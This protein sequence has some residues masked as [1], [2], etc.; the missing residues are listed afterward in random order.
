[1][2]PP[3]R[4][5]LP[6]A[7]YPVRAGAKG[8]VVAQRTDRGNVVIVVLGVAA[9]VLLGAYLVLTMAGGPESARVTVGATGGLLLAMWLTAVGSWSKRSGGLPR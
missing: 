7:C 4:H 5:V 3:L 6:G 1:M 8:E 2:F 9:L